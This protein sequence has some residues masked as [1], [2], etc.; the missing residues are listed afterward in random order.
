MLYLLAVKD[1]NALPARELVPSPVPDRQF[2][3][4]SL[5]FI[6]GL[7]ASLLVSSI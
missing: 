2:D 1:F 3:F 7:L 5:D 6:T 4:F